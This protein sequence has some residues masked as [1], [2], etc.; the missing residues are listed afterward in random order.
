M[1]KLL[2]IFFLIFLNSKLFSFEIPNNL[3]PVDFSKINFENKI[4]KNYYLESDYFD[5]EKFYH[6]NS[7]VYGSTPSSIDFG[8]DIYTKSEKMRPATVN[9]HM[10]FVHLYFLMKKTI[11]GL[12]AMISKIFM[13]KL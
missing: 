1:M 10:N 2:T 8:S 6:G 5:F 13:Q 11:T 4:F 7:L 9:I 3:E 12:P